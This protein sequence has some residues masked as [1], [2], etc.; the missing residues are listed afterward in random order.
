[1]EGYMANFPSGIGGDSQGVKD[2][3]SNTRESVRL[4]LFST[5]KRKNNQAKTEL[6][7]LDSAP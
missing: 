1:M 5:G 6:G 3:G 2:A 4:T 7:K